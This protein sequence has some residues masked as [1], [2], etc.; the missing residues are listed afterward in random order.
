M[1]VGAV[2]S[3][4]SDFRKVSSM[5]RENFLYNRSRFLVNDGA[6]PGSAKRDFKRLP[7]EIGRH[8]YSAHAAVLEKQSSAGLRLLN[9][10]HQ[11][12]RMQKLR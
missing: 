2:G 5:L 10:K 8:G 11:S 6:Y 3:R 4:M 1:I 12:N 9:R 7:L